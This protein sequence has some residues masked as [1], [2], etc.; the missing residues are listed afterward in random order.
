MASFLVLSPPVYHS[1]SHGGHSVYKISSLLVRGERI[2]RAEQSFQSSECR[3]GQ[4]RHQNSFD[5]GFKMFGITGA[6]ED[7]IDGG[8][9]PAEAISRFRDCRGK[10]FL[11][12]KPKRIIR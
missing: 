11:E 5:I 12:K 4:G 6:G 8:F 7:N 9:M 2:Q 10:P 3:C 1:G